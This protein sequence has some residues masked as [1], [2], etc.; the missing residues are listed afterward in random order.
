MY[1]CTVQRYEHPGRL[2]ALGS[3]GCWL[4]GGRRKGV[5]GGRQAITPNIILKHDSQSGGSTRQVYGNGESSI[6]R[7]SSRDDT[8]TARS[9]LR[10]QYYT[11]ILYYNTTLSVSPQ[12]IIM[13]CT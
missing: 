8:G 5:G 3:V 7:G 1:Y 13:D 9:P 4:T 11:I 2:V 6:A 10:L 12:K